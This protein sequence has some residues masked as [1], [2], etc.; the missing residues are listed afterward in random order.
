MP[1]L[2]AVKDWRFV[3]ADWLRHNHDKE[4]PM[5]TLAAIALTSCLAGALTLAQAQT[6]G[7]AASPSTGGNGT[8]TGLNNGMVDGANKSGTGPET[9]KAPKQGKRSKSGSSGSSNGSNGNSG[10]SGNSGSDG[11]TV[12]PSGAS[13]GP[14]TH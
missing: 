3:A 12:T 5:K 11:S 14:V 8:G 10:S 7:G 13:S 1:V 4:I 9:V 6:S 2:R